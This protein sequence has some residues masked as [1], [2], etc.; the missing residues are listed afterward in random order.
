ME[1]EH[2]KKKKELSQGNMIIPHHVK[3]VNKHLP[4]SWCMLTFEVLNPSTQNVPLLRSR[5]IT[6]VIS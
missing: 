6:D 4:C 2:L 3:S 5:V 1:K